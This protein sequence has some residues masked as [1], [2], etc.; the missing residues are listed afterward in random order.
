VLRG[1]SDASVVQRQQFERYK[2]RGLVELARFR[3]SP[4]MLAARAGLPPKISTALGNAL[5]TPSANDSVLEHRFLTDPIAIQGA[6]N[7]LRTAMESAKR[8]DGHAQPQIP[9]EKR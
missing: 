8:F 1:E 4:N 9:K 5:R 7:E 2:H 6:L 3:E